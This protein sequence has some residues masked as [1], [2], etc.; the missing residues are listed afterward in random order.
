MDAF[1]TRA[2]K[3][4]QRVWPY[5]GQN[6]VLSEGP[7]WEAAGER[8]AVSRIVYHRIRSR[9]ELSDEVDGDELGA[10]ESD[11]TWILLTGT[12]RRISVR[13]GVKAKYRRLASLEDAATGAAVISR[14]FQ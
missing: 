7:I 6:P 8:P 3:T 1:K 13:Q 14:V 11:G 9:W 10:Q 5:L 4:W 2:A 12:Y